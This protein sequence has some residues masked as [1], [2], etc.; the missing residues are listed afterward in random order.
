MH[1]AEARADFRRYY[2][3][4]FDAACRERPL[5]AADLA[6]MLPA[7]SRTVAAMRPGEA[8]ADPASLLTAIELE[9]RCIA[10]GMAGERGEQRPMTAGG[11]EPEGFDAGEMLRVAEALGVEL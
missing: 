6:A 1:L 3:M 2:A 5:Y 8:P 11:A 4:D 9:L 10:A 7:W